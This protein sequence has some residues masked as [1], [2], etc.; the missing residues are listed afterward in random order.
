MINEQRI[1]L[2]NETMHEIPAIVRSSAQK[3]VNP[4]T[5]S[6]GSI[7]NTPLQKL[8]KLKIGA[9]VML[10]YNIDVIDSLTNGA[11][12]EVIGLVLPTDCTLVMSSGP[13]DCGGRC[14][15]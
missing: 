14:G 11:F 13:D 7:F 3:E 9:K 8:L 2:I 12:G 4:K 5:S 1:A 6:D 15:C 10:T